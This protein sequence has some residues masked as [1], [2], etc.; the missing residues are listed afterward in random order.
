[1]RTPSLSFALLEQG[2]VRLSFP[3]SS[4]PSGKPQLWEDPVSSCC[5]R[6]RLP[7]SSW[8]PSGPAQSICSTAMQGF[9]QPNPAPS[10]AGISSFFPSSS[11][12][13]P[14]PELRV[15]LVPLSHG[16]TRAAGTRSHPGEDTG[17]GGWTGSTSLAACLIHC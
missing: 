5:P 4:I 12:E 2:Q 14:G 9:P 13:F 8:G 16:L 1:M 15:R 17:V 11:P 7:D 6:Q 3:A 10:L